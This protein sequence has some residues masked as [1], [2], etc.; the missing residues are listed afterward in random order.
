MATLDDIMLSIEAKDSAS[1][2][3]KNV[4][5][6]A[7]SMAS[8]I[9]NALNSANTGFMNLSNVSNNLVTSLSNG[10]TAAQLL[11]DTTSK[12]ETNSVLVNMMSD[13]ADAAANLNKHI[14]DVTNT[15]LVSMQNLIPAMNAFKTA[16]GATDDQIYD[17]TEGIA[18]FGAKVLAQTGS[19]ELSEQAM[20]DLSKGIKGACASLDQYGI[21]EDALKRTGKWSGDEKDI[22]GYI[23]A[24]KEL[25]GD[26]SALMETNEGLDA[27][28][29][30]AF[31]SA[32]KK[33]GNEFLPQIKD[34]KK[35]FLELN[36][37]TG[38]DLAAGIIVA[39]QGV[40]MFS[41]GMAMAAQTSQGIKGIKDG[42]SAVSDAVGIA[43]DWLKKF[44]EAEEAA[45]AVDIASGLSGVSPEAIQEAAA[46]GGG[47][48]SFKNSPVDINDAEMLQDMIDYQVAS[49]DGSLSK[50][51]VLEEK[52]ENMNL[53][54]NALKSE[55]EIVAEAV[56]DIPDTKGISKLSKTTEE[57]VEDAAGMSKV[58]PKAASAGAG[59]QASSGGLSAISSGAMSMLVPLL[60]IAVVIAVMIPVVTA[61]AAEALLCVKGIQMLVDALDFGGIDINDDLEGIKKIGELLLNLGIVMAEMTFTAVVTGMY[62]FVSGLF[63]VVNPIQ[64]A[65]DQIKTVVPIINQLGQ[66]EDIND[67]IPGKLEKLGKSLQSISTAT[68]AMTSTSVTVGW[69][70]FVAWV[71]NF[72][73]S[74][75]SISQAKDDLVKAA[76]QINQLKDL[77]EIDSGVASKLESIGKSLKGVSDSFNA[78]RGIR[79]NVNWDSS[80]GQLFKGVDIQTALTNVKTDITNAA[81]ALKNFGDLPDIPQDV[82][83][84]LSK[85]GDSLKGV[86]DSLNALRGMRDNMNWDNAMSQI[87][88]GGDIATTLTN[89]RND[90]MKAANVL[91]TFNSLPDVQEGIATKVTRVADATKVVGNAINVMQGAN[92]PDVT[93]LNMLPTKINTAK[94][95][96]SKT[97]AQLNTLVSIQEIQPGTATKVTRVADATK[98]VGNAINVMQGANIPDAGI[99]STLPSKI[100]AAKN[101][102]Q[103]TAAELIGLQSVQEIPEGLY[104]KVSRVGTSAQNVGTAVSA[105]RTIPQ[106]NE[107][108]SMKVQH[109]V[110]AVKKTATELNKLSGT[111]VNDVGGILSSVRNA[112][113][114]LRSTLASMGGSFQASS[115]GIGAGIKAGVV[116]GMAGLPGE[117]NN[118]AS[119]A[120]SMFNATMSSG[121]TAAG[122]AAR[123][124]FQGSF[125]LADIAS[126]E[127]NYAVQAVNNGSGALADACRQ[128]AEKA[129]QA[130]KNGSGFAS[131]GYV[132]R[133]WGTEIGEYSVQKVL[134]GS[135]ALIRTVRDTA[136]RVVDAWG[137]PNLGINTNLGMLSNIPTP[138][139][140][141]NMGLMGKIMP[142]MQNTDKTI[143]FNI[144][145]GAFRLDARNLTQTECQK[146]VTLGLEGI[147]QVNDVNIK[148]V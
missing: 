56:G 9:T 38:G 33:I 22:K 92:I 25:T 148:G 24:V 65:V 124:A 34:V 21:T 102:V 78:L 117:V 55:S 18:D 108:I 39:A 82:G 64:V 51:A 76:E 106:A 95:V 112:M 105:I 99:L 14:D 28:L 58:G 97:A 127:M 79:D 136:R 72:T 37:S 53:S 128:A 49:A 77:P 125:K 85:I 59:M 41:Q 84:K 132:A 30:K 71:F 115:T 87:F 27:R 26:T 101:V 16:T 68:N 144:T 90:L 61:L 114:Q 42:F 109:A 43:T 96:I 94:D 70:N 143:I 54:A 104:T 48:V 113:E 73:S 3:F 138:Q 20:M 44:R 74:T 17:A 75:D 100:S 139:S 36:S 120:M 88:K 67:S 134:E 29:G 91:N 140:M 141:Q 123:S 35:A 69:G 133:M 121:A 118:Q 89:V 23:A 46:F 110:N 15:S 60:S 147:R 63:L 1:N 93:I 50:M 122:N 6:N 130:A 66:V 107:G 57:V 135:S 62:N 11:F 4:G 12:A 146:I 111:N 81:N 47:N 86:S 137:T 19:V 80:I 32:G 10:K 8:T 145:D 131:P 7:Q 119:S 5:S 116:A 129:V 31:S 52:Y 126:A 40:D 83:S 45:S 13:S 98:V 103:K 142:Q 2:V